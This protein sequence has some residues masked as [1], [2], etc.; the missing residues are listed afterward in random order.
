[1]TEARGYPV[2]V[3]RGDYIAPVATMFT[4]T[5]PDVDIDA[6]ADA[7]TAHPARRRNRKR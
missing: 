7:L 6:D 5:E 4:V 1:L 2:T 3:R